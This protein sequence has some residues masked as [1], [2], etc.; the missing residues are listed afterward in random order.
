MPRSE[1]LR[2]IVPMDLRDRD[3]QQQAAANKV[4]M[5]YLDRNARDCR[6]PEKLLTGITS[7]LRSSSR[8]ALRDRLT[9]AVRLL[10][11]LGIDL[12]KLLRGRRCLTTSVFSNLGAPLDN[13]PL[14]LCDG[15]LVVGTAK[16]ESLEIVPPLRPLTN[17]SMVTASCAGQL[18][19]FL[20]YNRQVLTRIEAGDLLEAMAAQLA[21]SAAGRVPA[22]AGSQPTD[23][24][25]TALKPLLAASRT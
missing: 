11:L 6:H 8:A 4:V 21:Q 9:Y 19:V 2:V 10:R 14:H 7:A 15:K 18:H 23:K 12:R 3:V 1:I 22:W 24:D 13:M 20:H 17:V 25:R 5:Q 16:L